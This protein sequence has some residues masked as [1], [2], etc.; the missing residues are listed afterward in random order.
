[1]F[2]SIFLITGTISL[3]LG[4]IGLFLPVLPTTP[5]ILLSL[6]LFSKGHPDKVNE[7]FEHPRL[8]PYIK[9]YISNEGIPL[10]AKI[11]AL[12]VLWLSILISVF[13]FIQSMPL[14]I[15][16]ILSASLVSMYIFSRKTK[17]K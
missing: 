5:F 13:I 1:M 6:F 7:I 15:M 12:M 4:F 14:R 11:K 16:I 9:D 10:Y 2:K 8:Q 17:F 3:G